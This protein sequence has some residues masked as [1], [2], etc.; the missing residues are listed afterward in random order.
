MEKGAKTNP[1]IDPQS[2]Q[3]FI[4]ATEQAYQKQLEEERKQ[5]K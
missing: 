4:N 1:F 2:Y 5:S 3:R